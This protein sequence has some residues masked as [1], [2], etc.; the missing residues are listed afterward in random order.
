MSD[1]YR[2]PL[3]RSEKRWD[4]IKAWLPTDSPDYLGIP[5]QPY[6]PR[7]EKAIPAKLTRFGNC[8]CINSTCVVS[9]CNEK[10]GYV[11]ICD[12]MLGSYCTCTKLTEKDYGCQNTKNTYC[13]G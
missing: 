2:R 8:E 9:K 10:E 7:A 4:G 11:S 3:S 5:R 1:I 6:M 13:P 12:G